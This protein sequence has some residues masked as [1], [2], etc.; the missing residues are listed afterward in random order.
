VHRKSPD[1]VK[2]ADAHGLTG[3]RVERREDIESTIRQAQSTP[4][5]AVIDFRVEAEDGVFP[6]VPAGADLQAMIRRPS[7]ASEPTK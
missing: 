3:F 5:T 2:L 7:P 6:M 1:F 4:G